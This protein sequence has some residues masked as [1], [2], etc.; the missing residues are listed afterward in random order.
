MEAARG[1]RVTRHKVTVRGSG[2]GLIG[3][4]DEAQMLDF[5]AALATMPGWPHDP[6]LALTPLPE[7]HNPF[8]REPAYVWG[9]GDG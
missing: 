3:W 6:M 9:E 5:S 7:G 4:V 1:G 8:D 2:I